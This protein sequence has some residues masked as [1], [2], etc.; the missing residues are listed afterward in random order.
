MLNSIN[1]E[2]NR[3]KDLENFA[4]DSGFAGHLNES[5]MYLGAKRIQTLQWALTKC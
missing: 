4:G 2:G 1:S 5:Y 3:I